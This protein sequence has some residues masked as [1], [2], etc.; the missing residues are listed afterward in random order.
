MELI[1]VITT[2]SYSLWQNAQ[3][4]KWSE[5]SIGQDGIL[6]RWRDFDGNKVLLFCQAKPISS[7]GSEWMREV[8]QTTTQWV[9]QVAQHFQ[10]TDVYIAAHAGFVDWRDVQQTLGD[11]I[12][13][14]AEF[15]HE[16]N[17][18]TIYDETDKLILNRSSY[19]ALKEE[20][21]KKRYLLPLRRL[22]IL[23]HRL[24]HLFLPIDLDLEGWK[25]SGF[26][27]NYGREIAEAYRERIGQILEQARSLLYGTPIFSV[28]D[29]VNQIVQ[30]LN[31]RTIHEKLKAELGG[32]LFDQAQVTVEGAQWRITTQ[33]IGLIIRQED[34]ILN[35]YVVFEKTD[36]GKLFPD[37]NYTALMEPSELRL[38][39]LPRPEASSSEFDSFRSALEILWYLNLGDMAELKNKLRR[40]NPFHKWFAELNNALDELSKRIAGSERDSDLFI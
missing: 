32:L 6:V 36:V 9:I 17:K 28:Q 4:Q 20:I 33:K 21:K 18:D 24:A 38:L 14:Y 13:A 12:K 15:S 10:Q 7:R 40:D 39:I 5:E 35:I 3:K 1:I 19:S 37:W 11:R 31:R 22:A 30:E 29:E 16:P 26:N 8:R 34:S 23:K 27:P 25:E 2:E